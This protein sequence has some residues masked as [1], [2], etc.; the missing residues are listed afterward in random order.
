MPVGQPSVILQWYHVEHVIS[1][2]SLHGKRVRVHL[3]L[4]SQ[5][6]LFVTPWTVARH[7]P[8]SLGFS[9]QEYW[10]GLPRPPPRDL[11]DPGIEPECLTSPVLASRFF[12]TSTEGFSW[13]LFHNGHSHAHLLES[14]SCTTSKPPPKEVQ[15]S[16]F[17]SLCKAMHSVP[18]TQVWI[19]WGSK[20]QRF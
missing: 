14:S 18:D 11:L 10:S 6:W 19:S 17:S 1:K 16:L 3:C 12:T 20:R 13:V 9:R 15:F 4:L 7:D 2:G 5:V 8:L